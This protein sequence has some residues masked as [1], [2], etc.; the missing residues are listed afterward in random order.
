MIKNLRVLFL[1]SEAAPF[2]KIGGLGDIAGSLPLALQN[3]PVHSQ[4]LDRL[5]IR[6]ALPL[7]HVIDRQAF[8]LRPTASF[9]VSHRE[10]SIL[11]SVYSTKINGMTVYLVDG[12]V[13]PK[14]G[15]IYHDD[16]QLD[17]IKFTFFSLAALELTRE[18]NWQPHVL[19]ANDWHTA[20][21]VYALSLIRNQE[22]FFKRTASLLT[23]HNLPYLGTGA[24]SALKMFGLPPSQDAALPHWSRDLPLPLGLLTADHINTVS[25]GY[26]QEILTPEFGSG[27]QDFLRAR[28][29]S[30]SGILNGIDVDLWDPGSDPY[31]ASNFTHHNLSNRKDNKIQLLR[32]LKLESKPRTPLI[33]IISRMDY[34]KGVDLVPEALD[35]IA[36][37]AWQA[38]ILGTGDPVIEAAVQA[39][40][41]R[42]PQ[43]VRVMVLF[44]AALA[45]RIYGGADAL[46][47]PS[48]YE[49]CGLT[50]MIAMR[51]G[52]VPI[53]RATGG[54]RD[55]I[56][57]DR[58]TLEGNISG[59]PTKRRQSTG[60]LYYDS[61]S[62][63]LANSIQ[64]A[65]GIYADQRRWRG[66]QIRGMKKDFSWEKSAQQYLA[67]YMSI[68]KENRG[69]QRSQQHAI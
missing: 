2:V 3:L 60:F 31:L 39:L 12:D 29:D 14:K 43:R 18:L 10:G 56:T 49:P 1:A 9:R 36:D 59:Q 65:L 55:T 41:D 25:P 11:T 61:S 33:A 22:P 58:E 57:D 64:R 7:H 5:D 32:E 26:A 23:I 68:L 44:D 54:L 51:Y 24:G 40:E 48:R 28:R 15:A 46:L 13:I 37:H 45:R 8:N 50:Q 62:N 16:A 52:N 42:Y 69:E 19:H 21:A 4:N 17:G 63:A 35:K 30:I 53:A 66:L 20:P 27:L 67:L 47:I 34:Q 38:I 6:L